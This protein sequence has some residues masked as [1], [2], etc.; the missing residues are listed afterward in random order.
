MRVGFEPTTS[1]LPGNCSTNW[2]TAVVDFVFAIFLFLFVS[3]FASHEL[4]V[5]LRTIDTIDLLIIFFCFE[6]KE[7]Y[8]SESR[9]IYISLLLNQILWFR[10]EL[11]CLIEDC[12]SITTSNI[13]WMK[14]WKRTQFKCLEI[15]RV[16]GG[17][18]SSMWDDVTNLHRNAKK[19]QQRLMRVG[20]EPTTSSL[21]WNC[22][23]SSFLNHKKIDLITKKC[24]FQ[25]ISW[26]M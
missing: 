13:Q 4:S 24:K 25:Y 11:S 5:P 22:S 18:L 10:N 6:L 19:N 23:T 16:K 15:F 1:S 20:L 26:V 3:P 8:F 9:E 17:T 2:A 21:P 14:E 7:F 12:S